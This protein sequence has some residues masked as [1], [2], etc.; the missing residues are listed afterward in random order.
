[1][2]RQSQ[3]IRFQSLSCLAGS[4][5]GKLRF[6]ISMLHLLVYQLSRSSLKQRAQEVAAPLASALL[7][8]S[9]SHRGENCAWLVHL[10]IW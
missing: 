8:P 9:A 4:P 7:L 3:E 5:A 1:M 6:P 2:S 10:Q